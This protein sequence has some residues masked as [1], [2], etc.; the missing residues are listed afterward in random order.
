LKELAGLKLKTLVIPE[1]ARTDLGLKHYLAAIE[2]PTT[3]DLGYWKVTD[4]GLKELDQLKSLESLSLFTT[5][6]SE[7]V[8]VRCSRAATGRCRE[9]GNFSFVALGNRCN[10]SSER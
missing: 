1:A 10:R 4:T 3:L 7:V 8:L 5:E 2:W 6:V 9:A